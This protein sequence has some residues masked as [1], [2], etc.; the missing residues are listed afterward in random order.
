M[1]NYILL[2]IAILLTFSSQSQ[3]RDSVIMFNEF[4]IAISHPYD[5]LNRPPTPQIGFGIGVKRRLL[6]HKKSNFIIGLEYNFDRYFIKQLSGPEY[7]HS[8]YSNMYFKNHKLTIPVSYRLCIGK[9]L[10]AFIEPGLYFDYTFLA[11]RKATRNSNPPIG[12][13]ITKE[14]NDNDGQ[15]QGGLG[16][17]L[18]AGVLIPYKRNDLLIKTEFKYGKQSYLRFVLGIN[19]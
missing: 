18:S 12:T 15:G 11:N 7:K 16:V 19:I 14:I 4:S 6:Q 1:K 9:N 3:T 5:K 2:F 13:S 17:S 10:K 8:S